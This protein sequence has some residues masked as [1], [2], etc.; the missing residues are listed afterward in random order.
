M[1]RPVRNSSSKTQ[2]NFHVRKTSIKDG[3]IDRQIWVIHQAMVE[4]IIAQPDLK[5]QIM[6]KIDERRD[7]GKMHHGAYITWYSLL[8]LLDQPDTFRQGVLEHSR[9][10]RQLRRK[11]PFV[12]ILTEEERQAALEKDALGTF[13]NNQLLY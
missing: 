4:K 10:M 12:G 3:L 9:K 13:D 2:R 7:Q 11:T 5:S 6:K 1:I 8:Q